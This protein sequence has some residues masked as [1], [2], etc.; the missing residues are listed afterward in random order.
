MRETFFL[1]L[2]GLIAIGAIYFFWNKPANVPATIVIGDTV[3]SIEIAST[4]GER[5]RGLSGREALGEHEGM[6][7]VFSKP[8]IY[9][10]WMQ[11]MRFPIDIVWIDE[12][13]MVVGVESAV[14]PETFPATFEPPEAIKYVLEVRGGSAE[15]WG[16]KTGDKTYFETNI[17]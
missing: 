12:T 17:Y 8:G 2:G 10:F 15:I 9:S 4:I 16:I 5:S 13:G 14:T 7:F 3:I 11:D 6:L 1:T